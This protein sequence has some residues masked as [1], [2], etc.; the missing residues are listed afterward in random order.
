MHKMLMASAAEQGFP[1]A[2]VVTEADL[3]ADGFGP[4]PRFFALIAEADGKI[5]GMALCFFKYSTWGS[6]TGLYLEDLFVQPEFRS[7]G[8]AHALM[9]RSAKIALE[10][11]CGRFH[12]VVHQDNARAIRFYESLGAEML[13]DWRLM[14]LKGE[15]AIIRLA[16]GYDQTV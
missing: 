2:V 5:A 10:R 11:G 7:Q 6:H 3:V 1:G 8:V 12:W 4:A 9:G 14:S 16:D 15:G 13:H